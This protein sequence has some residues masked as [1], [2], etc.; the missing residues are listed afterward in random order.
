MAYMFDVYTLVT[1]AVFGLAGS[2]I[3]ALFI[4][5]QTNEYL[6]VQRAIRKIVTNSRPDSRTNPTGS[7]HAA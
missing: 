4:A 7:R 3:L 5:N 6:G 1:V 2:L